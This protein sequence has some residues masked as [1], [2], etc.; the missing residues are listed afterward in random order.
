MD[1]RQ[2]AQRRTPGVYDVLDRQARVSVLVAPNGFHNMGQAAWRARFPEALSFAPA[3]AH[4]RLAKKTPDVPY[5]PLEELAQ[6]IGPVRVLL[7]DGMKSPDLLIEIPNPK[8]TIWWAGDQF[9]NNTASDQIWPLRR[10]SRFVGSGPGYRCNSQ[11]EL[12]YVRDRTAWLSSIRDALEKSPPT[13]VVPAHGDAV[14]DN[15]AQRTRRAM[16]AIDTRKR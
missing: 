7:P 1:G 16:E 4:A 8:G 5:L 13:V 10:L 6:R 11:P 2:S 15:T 9:S 14:T 12:V 3:G